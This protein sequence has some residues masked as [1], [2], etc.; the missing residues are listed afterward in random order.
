MKKSAA[1]VKNI[2]K[3]VIKKLSF[4]KENKGE[5]IRRIW[6]KII[7]RRFQPHTQV[8]SFRK[9]RLIVNVDS[10]SWLYELTLHKRKIIINLKKILK[11]E[12]KELQFR[13]SDIKER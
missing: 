12:F 13:I 2:T 4:E 11:N 1:H 6:D 9:K 3:D 8:V 5:R 7:E 10:S